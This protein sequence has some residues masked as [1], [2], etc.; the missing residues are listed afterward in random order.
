MFLAS[1]AFVPICVLPILYLLRRWCNGGVC[2]NRRRLD[3]KIVVITGASSGIGKE[4][5]IEIARRGATVVMVCRDF[6]RGTS[7]LNEVKERSG[8]SNVF[9]KLLDL[10]SLEAVKNFSKY[11]VEE[12]NALHVL[13]NN[14]AVA[15]C[16][17]SK[18][19]DGFEMQFGVNHLSHFALTNLLLPLMAKSAPS[20]VI[21]VSSRFSQHSMADIRLDDINSEKSYSPYKAYCQSKLANVLFTKELNKK[22]TG[23]GIT[24]YSLHPGV[25]LTECGRHANILFQYFTAMIS[26]FVLKTPSQ[27]AQTTIYCTVQEGIENLSG[28]YFVDCEVQETQY[29]SNDEGL[30]KE[31]WELSEEM[32]GVKCPL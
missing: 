18:T 32:T 16:P 5:A 2:H 11:F 12:F 20:R 27:A 17:Y 3:G 19:R 13:I 6:D 4:T 29:R 14:A 23:S 21:N 25:A 30:A 22:L 31:L 26:P 28:K 24:T 15:V 1:W 8:N 7:A 10:S 9:L